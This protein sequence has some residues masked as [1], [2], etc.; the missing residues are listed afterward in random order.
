MGPFNLWIDTLKCMC[1]ERKKSLLSSVKRCDPSWPGCQWSTEERSNGA[2]REWGF[3]GRLWGK[4]EL[5]PQWF[6]PLSFC[7]LTLFYSIDFFINPLS[8]CFSLPYSTDVSP[9]P[10]SPPPPPQDPGSAVPPCGWIWYKYWCPYTNT[11]TLGFL[12]LRLSLF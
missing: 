7:L 12:Y 3:T 2:R 6:L 5:N 11:A 8:K 9:T 10:F 1:G 4:A